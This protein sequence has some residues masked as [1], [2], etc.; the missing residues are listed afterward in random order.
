MAGG[1]MAREQRLGHITQEFDA[2]AGGVLPGGAPI[3]GPPLTSSTVESSIDFPIG[4]GALAYRIPGTNSSDYAAS[5]VLAKVFES[6]RGALADLVASGKT[7]AVVNVANAFPEIGA[8]FLLAIPA[9]GGTPQSAQAAVSAALE[10]YRTG[11]V[12]PELIDAAKERLLSAHAYRQASITGL[13]FAWAEANA[14][15][16]PSP[17][18]TYDAIAAVTPDDVDRVLRTYF[19]DDHR[20]AIV[21]TPKP[22]SSMPKVDPNAGVERVGYTPKVHEALPPWAQAALK[23]PLRAPADQTG[24]VSVRLPNGLRYSARRETTAPAVVVRG[25]IRTSPALYE[26]KGKDGV[27]LILAELMPWGTT[28]LDR[29]AYEAQFDAIA[30]SAKLGTAFSITVQA[31]DFERGIELL[32]DGMLRPALPVNGLTVVKAATLQSVAPSNTPPKTKADLAQRLAL[33]APGDPHRRD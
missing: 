16:R 24:T 20:L 14:H 9:R 26:P 29:K 10:T 11:G 5:E 23:A 2:I 28:S 32:A 6:G 30:G 22:S 19:T 12:P 4:F 3:E 27:S 31:K 15:H 13:A 8:D 1:E 7:L 17:D 21:I 33:Y 18:A 25:V